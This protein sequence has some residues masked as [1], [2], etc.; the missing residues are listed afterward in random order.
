MCPAVFLLMIT[1]VQNGTL[2]CCCNF[3]SVSIML[4]FHKFPLGYEW[5]GIGTACSTPEALG[6][7]SKTQSLHSLGGQPTHMLS[8]TVQQTVSH[9]LLSLSHAV[10][11]KL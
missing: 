7:C 1:E 3:L 5:K 10:E 2:C 11:R 8:E 6:M 4:T 9:N